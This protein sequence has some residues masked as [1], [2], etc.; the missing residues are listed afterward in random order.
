MRKLGIKVAV[1]GI[2]FIVLMKL[3]GRFDNIDKQQA[4]T[5]I[6]YE[7]RMH[8]GLTALI[9]YFAGSSASYSGVNPAYFDSIGLRTYNLSIAAAGPGFL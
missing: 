5:L 1:F 6:S 4:L 8:I 3:M 2:V 9:F 7:S